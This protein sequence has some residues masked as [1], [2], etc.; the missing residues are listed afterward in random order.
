VSEKQDE[1]A[2][3]DSIISGLSDGYLKDI[4]T[5]ERVAI[6]DAIRNDLCFTDFHGRTARMMADIKD[7]TEQIKAKRAEL[8]RI[9]RDYRA[10]IDRANRLESQLPSVEQLTALNRQI[11]AIANDKH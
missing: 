11:L 8:D 9:T 6:V 1:I 5:T 2:K 7:L 4:L 10:V 3:L